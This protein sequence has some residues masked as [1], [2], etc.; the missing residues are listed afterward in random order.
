MRRDFE[1]RWLLSATT[2]L[3]AAPAAATTYFTLEQAQQA[4]FPG[5]VLTPHPVALTPAQSKAVQQASGV[6]V[7]SREVKVWRVAG[8]G[9]FY[10]DQVLGKHE[11]I[12][13]ALALDAQGAVAGLEILDYRE[14]YGGAIRNPQ[15]RAQFAGKRFGAPIKLDADIVNLS[16]A[17]LSSAHIADGVRRLLAT[18]ALA[19]AHHD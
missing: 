19:V 13:Y 3:A 9:W 2:L 1:I 10:L 4:L 18:H 7:R 12:T 17:T 8:G 16:G 11:F 15:W 6:H 5:Q 14:T